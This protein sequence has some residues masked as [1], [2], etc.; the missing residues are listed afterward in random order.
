MLFF[1]SVR[2]P[3]DLAVMHVVTGTATAVSAGQGQ[4]VSRTYPPPA[5][6][7]IEVNQHQAEYVLLNRNGT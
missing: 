5:T 2:N 7:D 1:W 6:Y 3:L 4:A